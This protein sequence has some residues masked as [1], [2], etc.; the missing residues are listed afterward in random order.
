MFKIEKISIEE[1]KINKSAILDNVINLM[2]KNNI[3]GNA[4]L[5]KNS[6]YDVSFELHNTYTG[7]ANGLYRVLVEE[8]LTLCISVEEKNIITDDK[9]IGDALDGLIKN[10]NLLPVRQELL[11][12]D[13]IDNLDIYLYKYNDTNDVIDIT[14]DDFKVKDGAGKSVSIEEVFPET[15]IIVIRLR[16]GRHIKINNMFF[17]KGYSKN[18]A[19]KFSL[20]N[21][22]VYYP[23]DIIPFNIYEKEE[24]K[25]GTRSIEHN[26]SSFFIKFTTCG[27]IKP[28]TVINRIIDTISEN[29]NIIKSRIEKYNKSEDIKKY[30]NDEGIEVFN[31]NDVLHYVFSDQYLTIMNM[32]SQRCYLLDS[33]IPFVTG[34]V[35]RFDTNTGIIKIVHADPNNILLQAI[36]ACFKD[37]ETIKKAF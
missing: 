11:N 2:K 37:L 23:T 6:W 34:G 26:S 36:D 18:N 25:R 30:Y 3:D 16:P 17:E 24:E 13:K 27:N 8:L 5:P 4:M 28:K 33:T 12:S 15:N 32:V 22:V 31:K 9:F 7:F 21:N 19:A 29:L 35:E 20:L 1:Q 14:I 10:I